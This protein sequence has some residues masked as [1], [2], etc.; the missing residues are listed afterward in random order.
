MVFFV[1]YTA[2][3]Y[4]CGCPYKIK[5]SYSVRNYAINFNTIVSNHGVTNDKASIEYDR[6]EL[7]STLYK[8]NAVCFIKPEQQD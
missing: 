6:R 7:H 2:K 3:T 8:L 5:Q 1:R 4:K